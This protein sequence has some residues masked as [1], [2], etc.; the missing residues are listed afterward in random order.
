[1]AAFQPLRVKAHALAVVPQHLDQS[2]APAAEHEQMAIV[3]IA[4]ERLLYQQSQAVEALAVMW[5]TT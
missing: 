4:L 2:T 3:R 5:C 1:M